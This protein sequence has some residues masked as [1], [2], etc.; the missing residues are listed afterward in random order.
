[1]AQKPHVPADADRQ[2]VM[3]M[4]SMGMARKDIAMVM[5]MSDNT[6]SK[7]YA[8]ELAT[9]DKILGQAI[10]ANLARQALKDDF[11]AAA[12]AM[13]WAKTRLGWRETDRVEHTGPD[14]KGLTINIVSTL[15]PK[16][17]E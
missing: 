10:V 13:F 12:S 15:P 11:K 16:V 5:G 14:G 6:L 1:M 8:N 17:A 3:V 9:G 2:K 7:H 4:V